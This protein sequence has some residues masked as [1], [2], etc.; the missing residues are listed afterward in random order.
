MKYGFVCDSSDCDTLIEV[1]PLEGYNFPGGE[2]K[3]T[4]PCGRSMNW[5]SD[6]TWEPKVRS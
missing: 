2:I 3:M 5:I 4:C 1:T 6:P